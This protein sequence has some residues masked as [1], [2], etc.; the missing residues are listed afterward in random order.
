MCQLDKDKLDLVR[1]CLALAERK[2]SAVIHQRLWGVWSIVV[3]GR[4][5]RFKSCG[6]KNPLCSDGDKVTF[7]EWGWEGEGGGC[8]NRTAFRLCSNKYFSEFQTADFGLWRYRSPL[9]S[10]ANLLRVVHIAAKR[11]DNLVA[12]EVEFVAAKMPPVFCS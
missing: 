12:A 5:P 6:C 3:G 9:Q 1:Y 8:C 4:L 7:A 11:R 10:A 2:G